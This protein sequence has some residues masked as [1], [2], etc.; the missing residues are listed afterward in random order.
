MNFVYFENGKTRTF[1][2]LEEAEKF[3]KG[4]K[5]A[6]IVTLEEKDNGDFSYWNI[7]VDG[8]Q[9]ESSLYLSDL[10]NKYFWG[11]EL[12][13][14]ESFP[15]PFQAILDFMNTKYGQPTESDDLGES[16]TAYKD[17][18][19]SSYFFTGLRES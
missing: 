19:R 6:K 15:R 8:D 9:T 7:I 17:E 14:S 13:V 12:D 18:I 2:N 1:D 11:D 3:A 4:V 16:R 5:A 10:E